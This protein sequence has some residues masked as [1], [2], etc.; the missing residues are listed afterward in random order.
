[1]RARSVL[2]AAVA[3]ALTA[4]CTTVVGGD[5]TA[6]SGITPTSASPTPTTK[7]VSLLPKRLGEP[8]GI[9]D[10]ALGLMVQFS[11]DRIQVNPKCTAKSRVKAGNGHFVAITVTAE[12]GPNYDGTT[13]TD[14][15]T[16]DFKVIGPDSSQDVAVRTAA[17]DKCFPTSDR[18]P[19]LAKPN[20]TYRGRIVLDTRFD[21]G[22]IIFRPGTL[23]G[24]GGWSWGF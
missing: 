19:V 8:A 6:M 23:E 7:V 9:R 20:K 18:L 3:A 11:F 2:L 21:S 5:P 4:A 15:N 13:L 12:T 17:A 22:T 14:L 1:M 24:N 16:A 10:D